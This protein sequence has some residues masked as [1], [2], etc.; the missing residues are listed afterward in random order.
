[1]TARDLPS[2]LL[3]AITEDEQRDAH[4]RDCLLTD[5]PDDGWCDRGC[6]ARTQ[7]RCA[8]LREI[9]DQYMVTKLKL[10]SV[11][12]RML[13]EGEHD[14]RHQQERATLGMQL[15]ALH[16]VL[17]ALARGY[18][19]NSEGSSPIPEIH[20]SQDAYADPGGA[21]EQHQGTDCPGGGVQDSADERDHG[22]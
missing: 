3:A 13:H 5:N 22:A 2:R 21:R 4:D 11:T 9:V 7:Q 15:A 8:A 12:R 17:L 6:C 14:D 18:G 20:H 16:R 19:L 1:M 10:V